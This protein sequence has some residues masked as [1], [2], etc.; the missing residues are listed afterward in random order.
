MV[1]E[2][3]DMVQREG[4]RRDDD[5]VQVAL[6][7]FADEVDLLEQ[8]YVVRRLQDVQGLEHVL[9][10]VVEQHLQLAEHALGSDH[11]G[12]HVRQFLQRHPLPVT[13]IRHRPETQP[14]K[15]NHNQPA[16]TAA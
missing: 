5:L 1:E 13:R 10:A 8:R 6:H 7:E 9:V 15:T 2:D 4:L 16:A 12:E 3:F 14:N 11:V